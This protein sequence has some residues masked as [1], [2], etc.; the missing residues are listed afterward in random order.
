MQ[1]PLPSKNKQ[2]K[3]LYSPNIREVRN[4]W[5]MLNTEV[6][7]GCLTKP[8]I[9]LRSLPKEYGWCIGFIEEE[10]GRHY[11]KLKLANEFFCVQWLVMI[12]AHE[13][14]HQYQ[15][16]VTSI[17][18]PDATV[19]EKMSHEGSFFCFKDK[20]A[21]F[22]IPLQVHYNVNEWFTNQQLMQV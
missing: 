13:M 17:Y 5:D 11:S 20:L 12:L 21:L 16:D 3:M 8:S 4:I 10:S 7:D 15:W 19:D 6:F 2:R 18:K 22:D 9:N 14:S 1:T